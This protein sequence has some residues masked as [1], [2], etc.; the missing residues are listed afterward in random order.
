VRSI[1]LGL[2]AALALAACRPPRDASPPTYDPPVSPFVARDGDVVGALIRASREDDRVMEPVRALAVDIGPRLTGSEA[3]ARA[4][5]WCIERLRGWGLVAE[6]ERWGELPTG[7]LRGVHSG[8]IVAPE[9]VALEFGTPAWSPGLAQ[10]QRGPAIAYP[11]SREELLEVRPRLPGA[12]V[13]HPRPGA[14][15]EVRDARIRA[16]VDAALQEAGIAGEIYAAGAPDDPRI[17]IEGDPRADPDRAGPAR[18]RL[19]GD[20]HARLLARLLAGDIVELKFRID[21][22]FVPG[23]VAAHNVVAEIPGRERPDEYVIV[24]AHL[25]SW[26]GGE[27]AVDNATGVATTLEAARLLML[28][29]ARPRRTIRFVLFSGEEQ[30][31]LGSRAYVEEHADELDHVSAVLV[32]DYGTNYISGVAVTPEMAPDFE[33]ITEA[34]ADLDPAM[35]FTV[36]RVEALETEPSDHLPF[37]ERGV[38]GLFWRQSGRADYS[39]THHTQLDR[40]AE[41]VPEYQRHS[42]LVVAVTA[43]GLAQLDHLLERTNSAPIPPRQ[44][45]VRLREGTPV[46]DGVVAGTLAE[47]VGL[48]RD[49]VLLTVDSEEV[50]DLAQ[51]VALVRAGAPKKVLAVRRDGKTLELALDF[52]DD[53]GELERARRRAARD[54]AAHRDGRDEAPR[55]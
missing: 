47:R 15:E 51:L 34:I 24:A 2:A 32:H 37:L 4:E 22:R 26:D 39:R 20:Q 18:I 54:A 52:S 3:L 9:V 33:R 6:R 17:V 14:P 36:E 44:L 49:D 1:R 55:R 10:E 45:G 53:P 40:L 46:V 31:L 48:R 8:S 38:P 27:G 13:V 28:V 35:P 25:D 21:D 30:G 7:F 41:V 23:P 12:F 11:R 42:A 50:V 19:R 16:Q 43:W 5:D 29:G